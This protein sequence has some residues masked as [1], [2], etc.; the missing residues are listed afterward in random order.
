[1]RNGNISETDLMRVS[2]KNIKFYTIQVLLMIKL[3]KALKMPILEKYFHK[4]AE[5]KITNYIGYT[6]AEHPDFR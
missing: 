1:M 4:F 5:T 6:H 3:I 2:R